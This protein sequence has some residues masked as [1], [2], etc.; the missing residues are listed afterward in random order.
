MAKNIKLS[1]KHGVN[2]SLDICFWCGT[3]KGVALFGKLRD[4]KEAPREVVTGY[5]PCDECKKNMAMGITFI[6]ASS[7]HGYTGRWW[8]L[9][10][11]AVRG[12]IKDKS[13]LDDVIEK[14]KCMVTPE[15]ADALFPKE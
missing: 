2:P 5:D 8:V 10:E 14:R 12:F 7:D 4:D 6:E 1:E 3:P 11:E 9:K 15:T 13:L